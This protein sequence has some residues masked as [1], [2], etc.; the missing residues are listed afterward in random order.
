MTA[1]LNCDAYKLCSNSVQYELQLKDV[2]ITLII[3]VVYY[4][5]LFR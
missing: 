3:N 2:V 5:S 4:H 1:S